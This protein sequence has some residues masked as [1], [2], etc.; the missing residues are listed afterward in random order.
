MGY[1][2]LA[3]SNFSTLGIEMLYFYLFT[4][5]LANII[6]WCV[7]LGLK[8]KNYYR[9]KLTKELSDFVLLSKSNPFLSFSITIAFFSLAGIP[10][11]L[12][13]ITK[14]NVF[15]VL[16]LQK[17]NFIALLIILCSVVSAFYY[18]RLVKILY[19]ENLPVGK[20][21][22]FKFNNIFIFSMSVFCLVFL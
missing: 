17:F 15:L 14:L 22:L 18:L 5:V 3:L 6:I 9:N 12:G 11:L 4:Y 16:V 2:L 7:I 1:S 19:F 20:L 21:Y 8:T 13:F 10:P